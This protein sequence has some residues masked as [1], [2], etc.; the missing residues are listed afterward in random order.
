[1]KLAAE[2]Y[3]KEPLTKEALRIFFVLLL[4]YSLEQVTAALQ[5]HMQSSV[6]MPKPADIITR[7]KGTSEDRAALAWALVVRAVE[8]LGHYVSVRFPSPAFHYAIGQMGGWQKLCATLTDAEVKWR[9]KEFERF[10]EIGERVASW[11]RTARKVY[12]PPYLVGWHEANNRRGGHALPD[13][14][15]AETGRP[16]QGL[17]AALPEPEEASANVVTA[18]V[19]GM[20]TG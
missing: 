16:I 19:R 6:F 5:G 12:V 9:G 15:D 17:R 2:I 1:M 11:E 8:C 18:L 14:V 3:G 4:P 10:F 13:V 20:R 7:I